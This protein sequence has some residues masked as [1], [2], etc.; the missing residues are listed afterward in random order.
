MSETLI[1]ENVKEFES[2]YF[3]KWFVDN[4]IYH[5]KVGVE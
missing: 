5:R 4:E 1:S 3:A 2:V